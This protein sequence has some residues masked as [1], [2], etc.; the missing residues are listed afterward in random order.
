MRPHFL[1]LPLA[2]AA[3]ASNKTGNP[4][5]DDFPPGV[6]GGTEITYYDIQGRTAPQLVSEMRRLGPKVG[7]GTFFGEAQ[8]PLRWSWRSKNNGVNCTLTSVSV[9]IR[10]DITM[11]RWTPPADTVP[12]LFAQWK[13]FIDGLERHEAGHKDISARGAKDI[14]HKLQTLTAPCASVSDEVQRTTSEIMTRVRNEQVAYD[15]ET[16]HG[17]TQG[18]IFPPRPVR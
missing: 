18:A 3:C 14:L 4:A 13:Q 15:T 17:F 10:S 1:L 8:S 2:L 16:R 11:P 12:G 9:R 7:T 6:V 5:L